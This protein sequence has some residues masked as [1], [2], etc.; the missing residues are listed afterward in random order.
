MLILSLDSLW[1]KACLAV[2]IALILFATA[3]LNDNPT[4]AGNFEFKTVGKFGFSLKTSWF[5]LKPFTF[6]NEF[7]HATAHDKVSSS[8]QTAS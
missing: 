6:F 1:I 2:C 8:S 4:N 7:L 3:L 5:G